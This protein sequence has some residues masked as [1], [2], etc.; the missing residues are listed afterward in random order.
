MPDAGNRLMFDLERPIGPRQRHTRLP[1]FWLMFDQSGWTAYNFDMENTSSAPK[2]NKKTWVI[3]LSVGTIVIALLWLV[4]FLWLR[5]R[6][7]QPISEPLN[8]PT[9]DG[10]KLP[11]GIQTLQ[12]VQN[13]EKIPP[14]CGD[15]AEMTILVV[16]TDYRKGGYVYGLADAIRLVQIDFT[17]PRVNV[18]ALPRALLVEEVGPNLDVAAPILLNQAYLFGTSGMGHFSG[19][20]YGAGALAETIQANFGVS[21][22]HYVVIDFTAFMNIIDAMGG[23]V[24]DLPRTVYINESGDQF[25]PAGINH[26]DG[27]EALQLARARALSS[28]NIRIDNQTV[29]LEA[30]F[31]RL[32]EP[33]ILLRIPQLI[34]QLSYLVLTD[35]SL[36]DI[37]VALC[38]LEKLESDNLAFYNPSLD[39]IQTDREYVPTM[40]KE[41]SIFRWDQALV[42]W[43]QASLFGPQPEP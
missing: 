31:N 40:S 11:I 19:S 22:D 33:E 43:I 18:V 37:P 7:A 14:V 28:D 5:P 6:L 2:K 12:S 25:F 24:V 38:L 35:F 10:P 20:G 29:I 26:L 42:D 8:L 23:I 30:I 27:E 39:L 17:Q 16:G 1:C 13:Q 4:F 41:M 34:E 32:R 9:S 3:V 21:V 36:Q 15:V